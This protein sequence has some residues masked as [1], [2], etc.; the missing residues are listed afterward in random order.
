MQLHP[1]GTNPTLEA[2]LVFRN[3]RSNL[4]VLLIIF[5]AIPF[6]WWWLKVQF[7]V[8]ACAALALLLTL[9]LLGSWRRRGRPENWVLAL[10]NSAVWVNLRDCE[11]HEAAPGMTVVKVPF[12]DIVCIRKA[13]HRYTAPGGDGNVNH[14]DV[15]LEIETAEGTLEKVAEELK[16]E[17][18]REVPKKPYLGGFVSVGSGSIKSQAVS[19]KNDCLR[20]KFK[21]GNYAL[22]PG[23]AKVL[24]FLGTHLKVEEPEEQRAKDWEKLDD[25]EFDQYI[26]NLVANNQ[27]IPAIGA[28][29]TRN[30]LTTTDA[31]KLVEQ[32]RNEL[33]TD[34]FEMSST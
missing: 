19:V 15:Y 32:V 12:D 16:S 17:R 4:I 22:V 7:L 24:S 30:G 14:K 5:W 13:I 33:S 27:T 29:R 3:T 25:S 28:L 23:I 20:V 26:K 9:P 10:F 18:R 8:Y 2:R 31:H 6:V 1:T 21:G 11:Y 34:A